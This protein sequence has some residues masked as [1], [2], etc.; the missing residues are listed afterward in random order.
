M[1]SCLR[2]N[3]SV[4]A[5]CLLASVVSIVCIGSAKA[6]LPQGSLVTTELF[7]ELYR[8]PSAGGTA[9]DLLNSPAFD[10]LL[11][12][13]IEIVDANTAYIVSFDQLYRFDFSSGA[14]SSVDHL[15]FNP[16]EITLGTNGDLIAVEPSEI[17]RVNPAT[18]A[19]TSLHTETFFGPSDAVVDAAGNIYLTEF[20]KGLGV[21][22]PSGNFSKIG[23]FGTNKF[24]H[25]DLG[26]DGLL[27]L[28]T[29]VG[30]SFYR[31][32]PATGAGTL[33]DSGVFTFIDDL[34][35]DASGDILFSGEVNS[36]NGVFRFDPGTN[37]LTTVV[38]KDTVNNGFFDPLDIAIFAGSVSFAA[39]DFNQNGT[40]DGTDLAQLLNAYGV[41][42]GGDADGDADTDGA[43]LL[44]WQRQ[45]SGSAGAVT[46]VPEPSSAML[47]FGMLVCCGL[48]KSQ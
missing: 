12:H 38:D 9:T 14:L 7:E 41:G 37:S 29:T 26:P 6:Q 24:S 13:H 3:V 10:K 21:L 8:I 22:S 25:V 5:S 11:G 19:E 20:F 4:L 33:L 34:Q 40:V 17:F 31:V 15:S 36:K 47:L 28:S 27:Y 2:G 35:V 46:A 39:A 30:E 23:N 45:F 1:R 44:E 16:K 32:N 42:P 48:R 18:G 43:D